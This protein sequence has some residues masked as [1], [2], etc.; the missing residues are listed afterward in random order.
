MVKVGDKIGMLGTSYAFG[1]KDGKYDQL[2]L[3]SLGLG[4]TFTVVET[5]LLVARKS[6]AIQEEFGHP[7][8][9][10]D[11][12]ITD[13]DG[14]FW[15]IRGKDAERISPKRTIVLDNITVSISDES[16]QSLKKALLE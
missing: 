16:Y 13:N 2:S 10:A 5:N 9:I 3:S 11:T 1:V 4:S 8:T 7:R 12:L 14:G 6:L 15:F